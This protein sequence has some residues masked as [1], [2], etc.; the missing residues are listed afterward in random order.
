MNPQNTIIVISTFDKPIFWADRLTAQG[1]E[2]RPY[3]K[4]NPKSPYDVPKNVGNEASAYLKYII[5]NYEVLPE[6]TIFLHDHEYS[7][8]QE[9]SIIDAIQSRINSIEPYFNFN[10]TSN[11]EYY[12]V[13]EVSG[14]TKLYKELLEKY[15]GE[16]Y[17]YGEFLLGTKLHAQ[18]QVHKSLIC[19]RP[20]EMY[21]D[22]YNWM[23]TPNVSRYMSGLFM[24]YFWDII[25]GQKKP[26]EYFP[27][28]AV[29]SHGLEQP[30]NNL[31]IQYGKDVFDFYYDGKTN[32]ES[33]WKEVESLVLENYNFVIH[34]DSSI[35]GVIYDHILT[36]L[37]Q[38][39]LIK[40]DIFLVLAGDPEG[41]QFYIKTVTNDNCSQIIMNDLEVSY[42]P[43]LGTNIF[44]NPHR[45]QKFQLYTNST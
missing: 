41:E 27:K 22:I 7:P 12:G 29:I 30:D 15:T 32:P 21:E 31:L 2:V 17:K 5:D 24:E 38:H 18:F 9:G 40:S 10:I 34:I 16:L 3:T 26:L 13:Y 19:L 43:F 4:C 39:N 36:Q 35:K 11:S 25:F 8:H 37:Y 28:I 1:F 14:F 44:H 23:M 45:L 20:K 33:I 6:Y 42:S